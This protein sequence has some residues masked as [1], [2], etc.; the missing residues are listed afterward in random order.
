MSESEQKPPSFELEMNGEVYE[1]DRDNTFLY[2]FLGELATRNQI[3]HIHHNEE[4]D[5]KTW[6]VVT[7]DA[8]PFKDYVNKMVAGKYEMHLNMRSVPEQCEYTYQRL[9]EHREDADKF[10]EEEMQDMP[11]EFNLE[12]WE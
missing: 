8:D 12:D 5:T 3:L 1:A 11:D 7:P 10:I 9:V 4:E 6:V 2:T